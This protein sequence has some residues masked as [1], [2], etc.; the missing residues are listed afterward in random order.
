M[1]MYHKLLSALLK[2]FTLALAKQHCLQDLKA[3]FPPPELSHP[4]AKHQTDLN[5]TDMQNERCGLMVR[6]EVQSEVIVYHKIQDM[7][8]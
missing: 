1:L 7:T 5:K 3:E 4:E 2:M 6:L 8:V